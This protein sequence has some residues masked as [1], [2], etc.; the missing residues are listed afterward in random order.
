M[1]DS[2]RPSSVNLNNGFRLCAGDL[3]DVS[4]LGFSPGGWGLAPAELHPIG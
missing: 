3:L 4:A 2:T 1:N